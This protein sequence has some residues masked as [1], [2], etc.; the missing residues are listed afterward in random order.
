MWLRLSVTTG[1][2]FFPRPSQS[3]CRLVTIA[4]VNNNNKLMLSHSG[5]VCL[6]HTHLCVTNPILIKT[7]EAQILS[8]FK[9][10]DSWQTCMNLSE[11]ARASINYTHDSSADKRS[12]LQSASGFRQRLIFIRPIILSMCRLQL[13]FHINR[14]LFLAQDIIIVII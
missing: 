8:I 11:A 5:W 13:W 6:C 14:V 9:G 2:S 10:L 4:L 3:F 1:F 7:N 12:Q